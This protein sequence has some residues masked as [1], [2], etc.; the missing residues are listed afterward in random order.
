ML[1]RKSVILLFLVFFSQKLWAAE[2][3]Q[4]PAAIQV[5]S[6]VSDG[7]YSIPQILGICRERGFKAVVITDRDLMRWEYGIWP[8]R[9]ILKKTVEAGSI[10]KYGPNRYIREFNKIQRDNPDLAVIPGVESA[11]FYYWRGDI[12]HSDLE[13]R[14]WHKHIISI[15]LKDGRDLEYLPVM[16][17][18]PGLARPWGGKSLFLFW[19][20]LLLCAGI[21]CAK[22]SRKPGLAIIAAACVFL[23]NNFPFCSYR[24]DQYHGEAGIKPFQNYIDYVNR[25]S[26]IT[27][28]AHPEAGNVERT[29][30]VSIRTDAH[31]LDLL[32][33]RDF[34][35]FAVFF[36]GFKTVGKIGGIWDSL[37]KDFCAGKRNKP[38]WAIGALSFDSTGDLKDYLRDLRTVLLVP[39]FNEEECFKAIKQGRMYMVQGGNSGRLA[40]AEFSV[41]DPSSG[42][43]K[44]MGEQ[45]NTGEIPQIRIRIDFLDG[46]GQSFKIKLIRNGEVI[47]I[48]EAPAPVN[49]AYLDGQA[50]ATGS[51]YYRLEVRGQD[52]TA[53]TNPIFVKR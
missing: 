5:S 26:G 20:V 28:W 30:T 36:E 8:L 13:I 35:G 27:F 24:F 51:F 46:Q 39:V 47:N 14:D 6:K 31:P 37:L 43:E 25:N 12:F 15:G 52:L 34:T 11:P 16:S 42:T 19:P 32:R 9:N 7:K 23:A 21:I 40:L 18:K 4:V 53:V 33:S 41:V 50:P 2:L 45:L 38:V 29:G 22:Y 17:N 48:F 44:T 49:I 3:I 10:I 1:I